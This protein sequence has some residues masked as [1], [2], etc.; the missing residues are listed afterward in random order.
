MHAC[1]SDE[2]G[3][4]EN[5]SPALLQNSTCLQRC[6]G[7]HS[8]AA[9]AALTDPP[10]TTAVLYS[11]LYHVARDR[12]PPR[13]GTKTKHT[14]ETA[15][16]SDTHL[17]DLHGSVPQQFPWLKTK[18]GAQPQHVHCEGTLSAEGRSVGDW[19]VA[20]GLPLLL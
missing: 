2:F 16:A 19:L 20:S 9:T 11:S 10:R 14:L 5:S 1:F 8:T 17:K 3:R 4:A 18:A 6:A 15:G 13:R 7:T 12:T